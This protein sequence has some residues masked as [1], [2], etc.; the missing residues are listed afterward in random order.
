MSE[1]KI[2]LAQVERSDISD[3][4]NLMNSGFRKL[5]PTSAFKGWDF[6]RWIDWVQTES[7]HHFTIR[8]RPA[9]DVAG[10]NFIAGIC[11]ISEID[12]FARH[13]KLTF[14][15]VDKDGHKNSLQ[16]HKA[17][18]TA[19]SQL[20]DHCFKQLNLNKVWIVSNPVDDIS[21]TLA[22]IGFSAEG[23][24]SNSLYMGGKYHNEHVFSLLAS[25]YN[26]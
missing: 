7:P 16:D 15:M 2:E 11:G 20:L 26:Q 4:K 22:Q 24:R 18:L 1:L 8:V 17:S 3:I 12:E 23:I 21:N 10:R 13:G 9:T 6:V 25:E 5:F 14:V 19:F